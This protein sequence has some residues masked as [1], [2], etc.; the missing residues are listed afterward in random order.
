M[1]AGAHHDLHMSHGGLEEVVQAPGHVLHLE[2][3]AQVFPLRGDSA[4]GINQ[5]VGFRV[6]FEIFLG[7]D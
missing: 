6:H 4:Q 1:P 5:T 7:H 3:I 2:T